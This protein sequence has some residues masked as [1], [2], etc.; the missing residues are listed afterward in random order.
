MDTPPKTLFM[1]WL[2]EEMSLRGLNDHQLSKRA[3]ISHSVISKA[4]CGSVPKWEACVAIA[5]GLGLPPELVLRKA[6]LLPPLPDDTV[7]LEEWFHILAQLPQAEREELLAIARLKL[8]RQERERRA[9]RLEL[10]GAG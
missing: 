3:G 2:E 5:N 9:G 10:A 7:G 1:E 4:R 8:A 6:S